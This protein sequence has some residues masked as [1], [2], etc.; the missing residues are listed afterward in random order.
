M[1][2]AGAG[3][4]KKVA[5]QEAAAQAWTAIRDR[6]E[7]P[8]VVADLAPLTDLAALTEADADQSD[9]DGPTADRA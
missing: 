3:R 6:H 9:P 4:T 5:E 8:V 1:L 7:A 2:G